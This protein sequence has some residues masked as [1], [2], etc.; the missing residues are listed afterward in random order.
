MGLEPVR[1]RTLARHDQRDRWIDRKE[2]RAGRRM[3]CAGC[4]ATCRGYC[5]GMA[6]V[7]YPNCKAGIQLTQL[8]KDTHEDTIVQVA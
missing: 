4:K 8:E 2:Q 1:R 6:E 7:G 3:D 5:D